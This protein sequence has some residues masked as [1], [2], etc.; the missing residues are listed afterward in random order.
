MIWPRITI[1]R[2]RGGCKPVTPLF[3]IGIQ[4]I[5]PRLSN[6]IVYALDIL[7]PATDELNNVA[8]R[9][10]AILA[11]RHNDVAGRAPNRNSVT[12]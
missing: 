10:P 7:G 1:P 11:R 6:P 4:Y 3:A 5:G 9:D 2:Y 8:W 12:K